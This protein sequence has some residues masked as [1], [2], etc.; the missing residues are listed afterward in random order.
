MEKLQTK[1]AKHLFMNLFW[2]SYIIR[3]IYFVGFCSFGGW[4]CLHLEVYTVQIFLAPS[5]KP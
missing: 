2:K 4:F 3:Y 1:G 5:K